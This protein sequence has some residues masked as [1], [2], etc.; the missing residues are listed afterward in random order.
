MQLSS[1]Y[2]FPSI[3]S[4]LLRLF[5]ETQQSF[6]QW[7]TWMGMCSPGQAGLHVQPEW[8]AGT[9]SCKSS[10]K[11][12]KKKQNC[13]KI[14]YKRESNGLWLPHAKPFHCCDP[15]QHTCCH[16][17][18]NHSRWNGFTVIHDSQL[19]R[20]TLSKFNY[21]KLFCLCSLQYSE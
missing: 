20:L 12:T 8:T 3:S 15:L 9:V 19:N 21:L 2:P 16:F 1:L 17:H 4:T 18:L 5:W 14:V 10:S 6:L 13:R 11:I 7:Y